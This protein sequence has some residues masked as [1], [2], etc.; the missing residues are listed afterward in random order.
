[1][2]TT[3]YPAGDRLETAV[4]VANK[5]FNIISWILLFRRS[6][7]RQFWSVMTSLKNETL[8]VAVNCNLERYN[9]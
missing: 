5:L 8:A 4:T 6:C 1:M 3:L 7:G 9:N 2:F